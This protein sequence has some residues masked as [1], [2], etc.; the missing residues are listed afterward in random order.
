MVSYIN[1]NRIEVFCLLSLSFPM[2][3][4]LGKSVSL[5]DPSPNPSLV[6]WTRPPFLFLTLQGR[7]ALWPTLLWTSL[8]WIR[9]RGS[10]DEVKLSAATVTKITATVQNTNVHHHLAIFNGFLWFCFSLSNVCHFTVTPVQSLHNW[11]I[12]CLLFLES[13]SEC[14]GGETLS[15]QIS[16]M[17]TCKK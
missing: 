10:S 5:L 7:T 15:Y 14:L 11:L 2:T 16:L 12:S 17:C 8:G 9:K 4:Y 6:H 1:H 3:E 13:N